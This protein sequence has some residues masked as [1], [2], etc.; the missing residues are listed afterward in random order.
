M[1]RDAEFE[2]VRAVGQ[3][4]SSSLLVVRAAPSPGATVRFGTIASKRLGK[5]VR[6]NR[7][8]RLIREAIWR[9]CPRLKP[10][11]DIVIVARSKLVDASSRQV[12][13]ALEELVSRAGLVEGPPDDQ[14]TTGGS[15]F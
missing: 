2:R 11:W 15:L 9:V 13:V 14:A 4:W 6:R 1:R 8:R 5:A 10:G 3:S 12:Q 7:M